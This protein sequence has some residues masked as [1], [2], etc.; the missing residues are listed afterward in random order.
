MEYVS[1]KLCVTKFLRRSPYTRFDK[2]E[3][4]YWIFVL[5]LNE[6][7]AVFHHDLYY[8]HN[9]TYMYMYYTKCIIMTHS[10]YVF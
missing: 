2:N 6:H 7:L 8:M 3:K 10:N 5:G 9:I 4:L 1:G